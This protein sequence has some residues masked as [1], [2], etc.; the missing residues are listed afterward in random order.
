MLIMKLGLSEITLDFGFL[1]DIDEYNSFRFHLH[2]LT[3]N[4]LR[5]YD[6][7]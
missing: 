4:F 1:F 6:R 5:Y 2:Q 3:V 7:G